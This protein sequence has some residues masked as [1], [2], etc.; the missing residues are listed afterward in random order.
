[1]TNIDK[2]ECFLRGKWE[3]HFASHL[4]MDERKEIYLYGDRIA[5]GYLWHLFSYGK[6]NCFTDKEADRMFNEETKQFCYLFY[7]HCDDAYII[8]KTSGLKAIDFAHEEDMYIVDRDFTW[9]YVVTH[10]KGYCGPYFSRR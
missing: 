8:E 10:E 7:Q 9:T 6:R 1:M 2:W 4:S 3:E 5:C